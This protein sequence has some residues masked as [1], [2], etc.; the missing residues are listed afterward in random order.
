MQFS[1]FLLMV[2]GVR[3]ATIDDCKEVVAKGLHVFSPK[4]QKYTYVIEKEICEDRFFWMSCDY[5]ETYRYQSY[6]IDKNTGKSA[7][8]PRLKSQIEPRLQFFACFD[9]KTHLLYLND[10]DRKAFFQQYFSD[11]LGKIVSINNVYTSVDDFCDRIKTLQSFQYTQ[12]DDFHGRSSDLFQQVGDIY[13]LDLP[14]KVQIKVSYGNVPVHKGK[15]LLDRFNRHKEQFEKV[16][17]IG[18]DDEGAEKV[19]DFSSLLEHIKI[20]PHKDVNEQ[21]DPTEVK[22]L[23][24]EKLR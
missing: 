3:E 4:R 19:F 22:L 12:I 18:A 2:D 23:L 5:D 21:Y 15:G 8:N 13:G 9:A 24:L 14:S 11:T 6:V 20:E 17:I 1:N 7:A 10:L 16:V